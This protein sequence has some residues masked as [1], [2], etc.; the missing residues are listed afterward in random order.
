MAIAAGAAAEPPPPAPPPADKAV[1]WA[2][3][4]PAACAGLR[5][6][7]ALQRLQ[8]ER[9]TSITAAKMAVSR[10]GRAEAGLPWSR[11]LPAVQ[12]RPYAVL[13]CGRHCC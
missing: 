13:S 2:E 8:P 12:R 11:G 3:A 7:E 6:H 9:Y 4:V 5:L 1:V 10:Q